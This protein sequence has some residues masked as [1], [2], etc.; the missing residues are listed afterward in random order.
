MLRLR[1]TASTFV[2]W[3]EATNSLGHE[4]LPKEDFEIEK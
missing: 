4:S 1:P 3:K 2:E